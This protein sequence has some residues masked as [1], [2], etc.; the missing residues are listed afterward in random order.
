[1]IRSLLRYAPSTLAAVF[2]AS[3]WLSLYCE[4]VR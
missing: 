3:V 2:A 4:L 1:M